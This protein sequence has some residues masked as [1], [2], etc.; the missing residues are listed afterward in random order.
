MSTE[1]MSAAGQ[2]FPAADEERSLRE[3]IIAGN[4][5]L[6]VGPDASADMTER[7]GLPSRAELTKDLLALLGWDGEALSPGDS[8]FPW[9]A[10]CYEIKQGRASLVSFL[11]EKMQV[12]QEPL[13][14]QRAIATLLFPLITI[15]NALPFP[16]I[17][18]TNYD[19]LLETALKERGTVYQRVIGD[20]ELGRKQPGVVRIVKLYGCITEPESMVVTEEDHF[21]FLD[22]WPEILDALARE[23]SGKIFLLVGCDLKDRDFRHLY[24]D[25]APRLDE[26]ISTYAIHLG[27]SAPV[28]HYWAARGLTVMEADA[29]ELLER[30]AE[31]LSVEVVE[32][33]S[34]EAGFEALELEWDKKTGKGRSSP[35]NQDCVEAYTPSVPQLKNQRGSLFIVA[36]GM[37]GYNAGEVASRM[38][39][40]T[41]LDEYY[42]DTEKG[43]PAN[44]R[45]AIEKADREIFQQAGE[46][47]RPWERMGTTV[48][49][50]VVRGQELHVAN[51]GDSR[52]YLI[53]GKEI[54]QITRDHTW[55]EDEVEAGGMT[56][57][58]AEDYVGPNPLTRAL[59]RDSHEAY[60]LPQR[61]LERGDIIVLCS[62]GLTGCVRDGEIKKVVSKCSP[63]SAVKRLIKLAKDRGEEDDISV[64]V[65]RVGEKS[66]L[67]KAMGRF[68]LR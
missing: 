35:I 4:C 26:E 49:A 12:V 40:D 31:G 57:E 14:L 36:D 41:I 62:D 42:A 39:V 20:H 55:V 37:G 46:N 19:V 28:I 9:V 5:V 13:P 27:L 64:I 48:V 32:E 38:A 43:I 60:I 22:R 10:Q 54:K 3:Q 15:T 21:A 58:Q 34:P 66:V 47:P 30:L 24:H 65:I 16:L 68:G 59:G 56:R 45:C 1:M 67:R 53:H 29:A 17:L 7:P 63:A 44:L 6:F 52:A 25:L 33:E 61:K 11:K 18:T 2:P 8:S 23:L 51:V 50:A